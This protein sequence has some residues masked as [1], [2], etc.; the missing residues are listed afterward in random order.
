M[1]SEKFL[2]HAIRAGTTSSLVPA[3]QVSAAGEQMASVEHIQ[4]KGSL[5][6][7]T[8]IETTSP[9]TVISSEFIA[10]SGYTSVEE[11]LSAQ[12]TAAGMS[13]GAT[14]NNGSGGTVTVNLR[15]IIQ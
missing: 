2:S 7:R 5:I 14:S 11:I 6:K 8:D 3:G 15:G 13:L 4:L 12:P 1:Y 10:E 9:I